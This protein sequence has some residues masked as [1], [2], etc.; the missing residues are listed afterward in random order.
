[1]LNR[2]V[3]QP[4]PAVFIGMAADT[5][6]A[7]AAAASPDDLFLRLEEAGVMLRIDRSVTPT[8]A[9]T[10]TLA[11]WELDRLRTIERRR[12]AGAHPRAWS[13]PVGARRR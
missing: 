6:E 10:P 9:K 13:R 2:A 3:V 5:V 1:M 8:M 11:R 7:A 12:A 4:D